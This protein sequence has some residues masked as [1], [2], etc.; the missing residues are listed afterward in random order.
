MNPLVESH[1]L[2]RVRIFFLGGV[3][4]TALTLG[5]CFLLGA[6]TDYRSAFVIAYAGGIVFAYFFNCVLVFQRPVSLKSFLVY[7]LT[8]IFQFLFGLICMEVLIRGMSVRESFAP[9]IAA[10]CT[11]PVSFLLNKLTLHRSSRR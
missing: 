10:A 11:F 7:P 4:N 3:A 6:V 9:V 1:D 8:Y 2:K 5:A